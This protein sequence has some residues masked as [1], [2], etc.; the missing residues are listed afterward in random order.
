MTPQEMV[1]EYREELL[2]LAANN[3]AQINLLTILAEDYKA[4]APEL[5]QCIEQ[6][7]AECPASIKIVVLYVI[8]SI[9]K[10]IP[11]VAN[12]KELLTKN[13][14]RTFTHVFQ[15]SDERQRVS[16]YKL[17]NTWNDIFP[18]SRLYAI[19]TK[20]NGIDKNWPVASLS[21]ALGASATSNRPQPEARIAPA[22]APSIVPA[23]T[24]NGKGQVHVN[25]KFYNT[26]KIAQTS[27]SSS[28][29]QVSPPEVKIEQDPAYEQMRYMPTAR[30]KSAVMAPPVKPVEAKKE[31]LDVQGNVAHTSSSSSSSQVS[32]PEVKI[33]V[34]RQNESRLGGPP[35]E[36]K[37]EQ[38]SA[39]IPFRI[40]LKKAAKME[41]EDRRNKEKSPVKR[42]RTPSIEKEIKRPF[43]IT[44]AP[45]LPTH[46]QPTHAHPAHAQP[47]H[48][49]P[50]L[51]TTMALGSHAFITT[52]TPAQSQP[53][54][55]ITP[56]FAM[57]PPVVRPPV[58]EDKTT[59]L[60]G[61]P[62]NNRIFV[63][64]RAYEVFY[65]ENVAV[66]E[67]N[68]VPHRVSFN[69]PPRDIII[70]GVA[71]KMG[72]GEQKTVIIEGEAHILRFGAPSR[73]LYMG[74]F[75]FRGVF[76][77]PPIV[78]SINGRRHE[79]RLGGP[80]PE[81]KIE[82]DPA[83]ELMRYMP[84]ARQKSAVM[85]PPVK[86][87]E[88]KKE[89]LDVLGLL[90]KLKQTGVLNSVTEAARGD[91]EPV[92]SK[93]IRPQVRNEKAQSPPIPCSHRLDKF[94][95]KA[96]PM[97]SLDQF[98]IRSLIYRYDTVVDA[99]HKPRICCP[100]CGIGFKELYGEAYQRHIDWHLAHVQKSLAK[101]DYNRC[102]PWFMT[103]NWFDFS[104]TEAVN[105]TVSQ[106]AKDA[107]KTSN[108]T[109]DVCSEDASLKECSAC[110]EKFEEY[111]DDDSDSWR[112]RNSVEENGA[113]LHR[114]CVNEIKDESKD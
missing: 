95:K 7:L 96:A 98:S 104:E 30:Q 53:H 20:I 75:P 94:E 5:V 28:S 22:P 33:H 41:P 64:G 4:A 73:E 49:Q 24:T 88:A 87:V 102:R 72:F 52:V 51:Q 79:I 56:S 17:R 111:W 37:I 74:N 91:V 34:K 65:L 29:S 108:D 42:Q 103:Q 31:T 14:V 77:G 16:L 69:G 47:T 32:P 35:P 9:V 2:G 62:L 66:I 67:R 90:N 85:A 93:N 89:T 114:T 83:Y 71:Y 21:A 80:P 36:V 76:G 82:Q 50:T 25:P 12:Y 10:N 43:V 44:P 27:S 26:T 19:D 55:V 92:R 3:K 13:I 46:A 23:R 106:E 61:V 84:T 8:D 11:E 54:P 58:I 18:K 105:S 109:K 70:D 112:F 45:A 48:A 40:P 113:L 38:D 1:E 15:E 86:P 97:S 78:A 63:D 110:K 60:S 68:G 39:Q 81:V 59:R 107:A 100:H 57:P 99:I 101:R 6:V